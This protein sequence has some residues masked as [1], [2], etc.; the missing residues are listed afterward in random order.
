MAAILLV[1]VPVVTG[2]VTLGIE[3]LA[4]VQEGEPLPVQV[5]GEPEVQV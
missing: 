3:H 1:Q 2:D 5:E 4:T